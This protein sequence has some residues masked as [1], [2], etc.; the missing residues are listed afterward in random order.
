[1]VL[2]TVL[3]DLI[4]FSASIGQNLNLVQ[5]G[6]GNTSLK[7]NGVLWVKASGKWLARA[8]QEE[9]FVP[10][11]LDDVLRSI[12]DGRE[13]A[14][15]SRTPSGT[16]L[17]PSVETTMHAVLP[18]RVVV[19]VHSVNTIAWA[20]EENAAEALR[21]RLEGL[22]WVWLP[23]V[24][25]GV[26]LA[27][28]IRDLLSRTP[29]VLV[30]GNHGLVIGAGDCDGASALLADVERRLERGRR[31]APAARLDEVHGLAPAGFRLPPDDEVHAI[32][33]DS[34]SAT[35]VSQG[36]LYPDQCVYLGP[37]AM[38]R[39]D[40]PAK[41]A[42]DRFAAAYSM[43]PKYLVAPGRGILISEQI[44]R[45]G[46]ELLIALK[47]VLERLDPDRGVQFLDGADVSRLMNWDAERYRIAVGG[48]DRLEELPHEAIHWQSR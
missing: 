18:H 48:R 46:W 7:D 38:I 15:E 6:G 12:D 19:H 39:D 10:A 36:L 8:D 30:L 25:P 3:A 45:A 43:V 29:D 26:Q 47:R 32:A 35:I 42:L 11:P 44:N 1:V 14:S 13:Y 16:L 34:Y 23:Y 21:P 17:R 33:T 2:A 37:A 28:A 40:T 24:H 9:M 22:R 5:A 41:Q 27:R 4:R 20:V 31:P